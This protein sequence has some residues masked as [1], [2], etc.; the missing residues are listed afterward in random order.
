MRR[1][2]LALREHVRPPRLA[3]S[4]RCG[5]TRGLKLRALAHAAG[6][7][8]PDKGS[9]VNPHRPHHC[10]AVAVRLGDHGFVGNIDPAILK[11][12]SIV[13]VLRFPIYIADSKAVRERTT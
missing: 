4:F 8:A 11:A 5:K 13:A 7:E 6:H 9:A 3:A 10:S 2:D 12:D 1:Q